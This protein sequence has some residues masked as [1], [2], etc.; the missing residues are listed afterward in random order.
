MAKFWENLSFLRH[1]EITSNGEAAG[2]W[3][4]EPQGERRAEGREGGPQSEASEASR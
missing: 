2:D 1:L 4:E 3:E